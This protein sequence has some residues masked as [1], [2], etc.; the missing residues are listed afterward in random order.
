MERVKEIRERGICREFICS[1]HYLIN[2]YQK[3]VNIVDL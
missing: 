1:F 3:L 2:N